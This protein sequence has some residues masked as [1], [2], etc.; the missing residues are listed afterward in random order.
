MWFNEMI[1]FNQNSKYVSGKDA[2]GNDLP[3]CE[4]CSKF[5]GRKCVSK[6]E[7]LDLS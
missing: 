4:S 2:L 3:D 5:P 7:C 6:N 1:S